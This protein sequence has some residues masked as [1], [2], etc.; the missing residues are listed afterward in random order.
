M[1]FELMSDGTLA[2]L[3]QMPLPEGIADPGSPFVLVLLP[4]NRYLLG[5]SSADAPER[6]VWGRPGDKP[7]E[8]FLYEDRNLSL[9]VDSSV[10]MVLPAEL[11]ARLRDA[12][13][14]QTEPPG[15]HLSAVLILRGLMR[16]HAAFA[17][18][19]LFRDERVFSRF[20]DTDEILCKGYWALRFAL[21]RGEFDVVV[22]LRAWLKAGPGAFSA[23]E[24]SARIW[25]SILDL[26]EEKELAELETLSFSRDDLQHMIAQNTVPLLLF[27]PRSG[28]LVLSRFGTR[29]RSAFNLWAFFPTALWGEMRE[30]RKLSLRELL[31]A[32]WGEDDVSRAL[33]ERS[34]YAQNRG[35]VAVP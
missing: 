15:D 12:L 1:I 21:A 17:E 24:A 26:P 23:Q 13:L 18:G 2:Q 19:V 6:W 28:Y 31:L 33:R 22:R 14:A 10:S 34:R 8:L 7:R 30:G 3:P 4:Y 16:G 29:E 25:F 9:V 20:L 32:V 27:N 5:C 35:V 11:V